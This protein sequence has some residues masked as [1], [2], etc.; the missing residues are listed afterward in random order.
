MILSYL[1][2]IF[3]L[4]YLYLRQ[5]MREMMREREIRISYD[6]SL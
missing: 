4:S 5:K 1:S 3:I 6:L 2:L